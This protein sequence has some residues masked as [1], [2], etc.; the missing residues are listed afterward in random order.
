M[1]LGHPP[2]RRNSKGD[3]YQH[4]VIDSEGIVALDEDSAHDKNIFLNDPFLLHFHLQFSWQH[5]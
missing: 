4:L 2:Q 1:D 5:R 3:S